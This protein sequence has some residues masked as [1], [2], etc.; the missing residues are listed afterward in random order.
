MVQ[1]IAPPAPKKAPVQNVSVA[2]ADAQGF[3]Q[4]IRSAIK[5]GETAGEGKQA[6]AVKDSGKPDSPLQD[7]DSPQAQDVQ[8]Q[9]AI[10]GY[11]MLAQNTQVNDMMPPPSEDEQTQAIPQ[12]DTLIPF[13]PAQGSDGTGTTKALTDAKPDALPQAQA[14]AISQEV[15]NILEGFVQL[16]DEAIPPSFADA[17]AG[18]IQS[19]GKG[20]QAVEEVL[21]WMPQQLPEQAAPDQEGTKTI[22]QLLMQHLSSL[23]NINGNPAPVSAALSQQQGEMQQGEDDDSPAMG[24]QLQG[25]EFIP[26]E[27]VFSTQMDAQVPPEAEPI[28]QMTESIFE[29]IVEKTSISLQENTKQIDIDLVPEFLGRVS[30]QLTMEGERVSAVIRTSSQQ[31]Q[32][33][34]ASEISQ[35]QQTLQA[36][37]IEVVQ[38]S[39]HHQTVG[40]GMDSHHSN[41][42]GQGSRPGKGRLRVQ[43][44]DGLPVNQYEQAFMGAQPS[45]D[46]GVEYRA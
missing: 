36:R 14:E 45:Q 6:G 16:K 3:E 9:A 23:E 30:I 42:Q 5:S 46:G 33:L 21:A 1:A 7:Q 37:G 12:Q 11:G 18:K 15:V 34:L 19:A 2:A 39:V 25:A 27:G 40:Q 17:L 22:E 4:A 35:L 29:Q 8:E 31:V 32:G 24:T 28:H 41:P 20:Q 44:Q 26:S 13:D 43:A 38:L 10:Q